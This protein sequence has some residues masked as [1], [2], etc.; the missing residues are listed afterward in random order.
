MSHNPVNQFITEPRAAA[1]SYLEGLDQF[2]EGG[3][4]MPNVMVLLEQ[5]VPTFN[6]GSLIGSVLGSFP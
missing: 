2:L 3:V 6:Y 1:L 4:A 5:R